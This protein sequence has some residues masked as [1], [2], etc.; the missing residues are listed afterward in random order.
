[1]RTPH[2]IE[3]SSIG[4]G[5]PAPEEVSIGLVPQSERERAGRRA[6]YSRR[7]AAR[8]SRR[9]RK[10]EA[11][12]RRFP[13]AHVLDDILQETWIAVWQGL[14]RY[15]GRSGFKAWLYAIG[16]NKCVDHFRKS[17]QQSHWELAIIG[18]TGDPHAP[19]EYA[20][21]EMRHVVQT[22]LATL[23][24]PQREVIELYYYDE[25]TLAEIAQILNRNLNTVKYQFYRA[26]AV[27]AGEMSDI[28]PGLDRTGR[29]QKR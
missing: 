25:L 17:A 21:A 1:V 26:H 22:A 23:A 13:P 12:A 18:D 3:L 6:E 15:N 29:H 9:I 14:A 7:G 27:V 8:R 5:A 4:C 11:A 28:A 2:P 10:P 16:V 24:G 20:A 19:D